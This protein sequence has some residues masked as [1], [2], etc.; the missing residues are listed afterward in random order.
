MATS[1][2]TPDRQQYRELV[3]Q[4]A[5]KAKAILPTQVNGRIESAIKLVIN[6]D[7]EVRDDGSIQ[8]AS[9][10]DPERSYQ[11]IGT[12]CTCQDFQHGKAPEGWCQHRIAAGIDKRVRE[13]LAATP[14]TAP[15]APTT[16]LPEAPAS[17]NVHLT[18]AGR[19]VQLT[20]RD[21]D[22]SRLLERLA[23]VLQRFPLP[24]MQP[25]EQQKGWC[26]IH[27]TPMKLTQKNGK[28][29]YSHKTADGW[30]KGKR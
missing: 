3:A 24:P 18:I 5:A 12:T 8:V 28:S 26:P 22:E 9:S 30:C 19:Q 2:L 13:L 17:V 4:V 1:T 25:T 20:L 14:P 16:P 7:V 15:E 23:T 6:G 21:S 27:Q 10:S 11:L 29:W